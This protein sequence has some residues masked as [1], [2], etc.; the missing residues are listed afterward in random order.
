MGFNFQV[1][2]LMEAGAWYR[3]QFWDPYNPA[4]F[5]GHLLS[6]LDIAALKINLFSSNL[7]QI[8]KLDLHLLPLVMHRPF[9]TRIREE[10]KEEETKAGWHPFEKKV[11]PIY[12]KQKT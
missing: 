8:L 2:L 4:P 11:V 1:D 5:C 3:S 9:P 7:R 12:L 6:L 10:E